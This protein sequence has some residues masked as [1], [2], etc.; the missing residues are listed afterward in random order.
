MDR[1][2]VLGLLTDLNGGVAPADREVNWS[3]GMGELVKTVSVNSAN[4]KLVKQVLPA[5]REVA[6][7][8]L[9]ETVRSRKW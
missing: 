6:G 1:G 8:S 5:D 4:G 9:S 3:N 2:E 7:R